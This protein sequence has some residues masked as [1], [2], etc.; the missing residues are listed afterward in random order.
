M[1]WIKSRKEFLNEAKI[2]DIVLPKQAKE[3]KETWGENYLDYE[4]V[5]ATANIEQG[6]WKL[7]DEDKY[8]V[9]SSF[10]DCNIKRIESDLSNLPDKLN[11][12]ISK[13]IDIDLIKE[14][15][16]STKYN[17]F[18]NFNI[19]SP[20]IDQIIYIF[21]NI[22]RK[23]VVSETQS[24]E[25]IKRDSNG[26]P[27]RDSDGNIIKVQKK[28]G[29]PVFSSNLVN[30]NSFIGDFN[31]CY[32]ED[33]IDSSIFDNRDINQL[34]NI[35][36]IEE[37]TSYK[38]ADMEIFN[39]DIYLSISHNPKDILN[40]SISKFY[41]SCQHFYGGGH[42]R[43]ILG[44]IFDPNSIPAFLIFD[45]PIFLDNEKISDFLPLSRM[46]IRNIEGFEDSE[47]KILFFDR[48]YPDRMKDVFGEIIQKYTS[49]KETDKDVDYYY[50]SPDIDISDELSSPYMDK[51]SLKKIPFIG[52]NLKSLYLN[53][54]IDWSKVKVSPQA[55][56]KEMVVETTD[57]PQNFKD[58][59]LNPDWIKFKFLKLNNL[60]PFNSI[61][62]ESI[63]FDKCKLSPSILDDL[64][65]R[66]IKKLQFISCD[67][68]GE[69]DLSKFSNLEELHLLY[70][71][72]SFD[73]ILSINLDKI[74][75]MVISGDLIKNKENKLKISEL[76]RSGKKIE[77]VGPVI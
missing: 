64:S 40:M 14:T 47:E 8:K 25:M 10:F 31:R 60:E 63:A 53:R 51:L 11:G 33:R 12:V 20:S 37:N 58:L 26:R 21:D 76:K 68:P 23:L 17:L 19:K 45:T 59:K 52:K 48:A 18:K 73:E 27:E 29:E 38:L 54:N 69:L 13:S 7:S 4:E 28:A 42:R 6:K 56:I 44:N 24:T 15:G 61:I 66:N 2:R 74:K 35:G 43:N 49:N 3:I 34:R 70:S 46:I 32:P 16:S 41:S 65:K 72:E 71:L 9:L 67:I 55:K 57:L 36:T 75:K 22:F 77:I 50:F 30:I 62:T 39:K 5:D 1:K